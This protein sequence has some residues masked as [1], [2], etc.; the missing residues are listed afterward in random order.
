MAEMDEFTP[1]GWGETTKLQPGKYVFPVRV[2][3][4]QFRDTT[5]EKSYMSVVFLVL[6]GANKDF[7]FDER[8]YL[9][10]K[11]EW[12][13][14]WFLK[15]FGYPEEYLSSE[16]PVLKKSKIEGLEGKVLVEVTLDNM[17]MLKVEVKKFDYIAG[18][19][20]EEALE[21]EAKK[22]EELPLQAGTDA[23]PNTAIDV[24][25]DIKEN[26]APPKESGF[27]SFLDD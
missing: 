18:T 8:V 16:Q 20:I 24:E 1:S 10:K 5:K 13:A 3:S 27:G 11:A 2:K 14:R 26:P 4:L 21:K 7:E 17:E 19:E 25:Q 22:Q 6:D 12:R 23:E 15:K 9:S